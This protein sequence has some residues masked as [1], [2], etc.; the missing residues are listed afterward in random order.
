VTEIEM[1]LNRL[2][3]RRKV[4]ESYS[5]LPRL[6]NNRYLNHTLTRPSEIV[7]RQAP[8]PFAHRPV[9][10]HMSD[11][12]PRPN[13]DLVKDVVTVVNEQNNVKT[14]SK[15]SA[16]PNDSSS[17]MVLFFVKKTGNYSIYLVVDDVNFLL[18]RAQSRA[19]MD[20]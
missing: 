9:P 15:S 12:I 20:S 18:R 6:I 3:R 11:H 1:L 8:F 13:P 4:I 17:E 2:R 10:S 5:I 7:K 19:R 16:D 14:V